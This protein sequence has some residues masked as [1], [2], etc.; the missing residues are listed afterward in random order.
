MTVQPVVISIKAIAL[1][2]RMYSLAIYQSDWQPC[3]KAL[4]KW[5]AKRLGAAS[6]ACRMR[7]T[8]QL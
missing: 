4:N 1:W 5:H 3:R 6:S 7:S 2:R 8:N